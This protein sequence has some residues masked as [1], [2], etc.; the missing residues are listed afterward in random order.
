MRAFV[1]ANLPL[2]RF[3]RGEEVGD[4]V[5][6][7][8]SERASLITGAWCGGWGAGAVVGVRVVPQVG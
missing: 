4:V 1:R 7:L 3:G 8:A 5:T 2:G 6:F